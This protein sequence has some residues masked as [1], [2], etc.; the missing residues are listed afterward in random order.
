MY[1]MV[2]DKSLREYERYISG[3][4]EKIH[5]EIKDSKTTAHLNLIRPKVKALLEFHVDSVHNFQ[6]ERL[7]HLIVTFFF[8]GLLI[9]FAGVS[10]IPKDITYDLLNHLILAI[11]LILFVVE[12]FYIRY[13]YYLE[14]GTQ[15]LYKYSK[16][17]FEMIEKE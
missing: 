4:I 7:I 16:K 10:F 14:N 5:F 12:I 6:H 9:L 8:G 17:L 2:M 1:N 11:T 3:E 13:Y 15:R